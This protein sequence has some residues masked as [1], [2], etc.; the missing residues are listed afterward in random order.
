MIANGAMSGQGRWCKVPQPTETTLI[1]G[2]W[3]LSF[4][5]NSR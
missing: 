5:A 1:D 2:D 3:D 4:I